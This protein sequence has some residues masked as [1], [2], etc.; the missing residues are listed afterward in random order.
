MKSRQKEE[1]ERVMNNILNMF[2]SSIRLAI[3]NNKF[4]NFIYQDKIGILFT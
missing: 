2:Q 3:H 4:P 1:K